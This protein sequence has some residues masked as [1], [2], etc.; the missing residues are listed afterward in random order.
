MT[1]NWLTHRPARTFFRALVSEVRA[2]SVSSPELYHDEGEPSTGQASA[3]GR[4][5]PRMGVTP[6]RRVANLGVLHPVYPVNPCQA[7]RVTRANA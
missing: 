3:S 7:G 4:N 5:R 2:V 1:R 6:V